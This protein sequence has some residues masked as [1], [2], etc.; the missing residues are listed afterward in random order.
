[1]MFFHVVGTAEEPRLVYGGEL[2]KFVDE[3]ELPVIEA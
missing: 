1:M 2:P 3:T